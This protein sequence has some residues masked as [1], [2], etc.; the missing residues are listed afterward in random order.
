MDETIDHAPPQKRGRIQH[1]WK[2]LSLFTM[3]IFERLADLSVEYTRIIAREKEIFL[4][5]ALLLL[6]LF[7]FNSSRYCDGNS[8]DY[9]SCTRPATYY[10]FDAIDIVCI[11]LGVFFVLVWFLKR[12]QA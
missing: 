6:G 4:G 3:Y 11:I 12:R 2:F 10:Y 5:S 7:N 8:A 9:L 1:T